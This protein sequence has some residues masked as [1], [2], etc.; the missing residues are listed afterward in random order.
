MD[1]NCLY[2]PRKPK[3]SNPSIAL[4]TPND[5]D[6]NTTTTANNNNHAVVDIAKLNKGNNNNFLESYS[7]LRFIGGSE[8]MIHG[9]V[10]EIIKDS[11][12]IGTV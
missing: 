12:S 6:D 7:Q 9:M 1:G 4:A 5:A 10:H 8:Q 11:K 3:F 2:T